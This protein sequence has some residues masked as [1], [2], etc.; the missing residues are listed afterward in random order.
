[1]PE[2][3][4][5]TPDYNHI[6]NDVD[7]AN[8]DSYNDMHNVLKSTDLMYVEGSTYP[9][10]KGE[11]IKRNP[12]EFI[13]N[14]SFDNHQ[15][16]SYKP[17]IHMCKFRINSAYS[18]I[19]EPNTSYDYELMLH[20]DDN[21]MNNNVNDITFVATSGKSGILRVENFAVDLFST[22]DVMF[23]TARTKFLNLGVTDLYYELFLKYDH[24]TRDLGS[25]LFIWSMMPY[26]NIV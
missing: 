16:I 15:I 18:P 26:K 9:V 4:I 13:L 11:Y 6:C 25:Q 17:I 3:V 23:S 1:M 2:P 24:V 7:C 19:V 10:Y 8:V 22:T 21:P 20:I 14:I 12:E 5:L